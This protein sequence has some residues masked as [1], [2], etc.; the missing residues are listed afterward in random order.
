ML[1]PKTGHANV[2]SVPLLWSDW[3]ATHARRHASAI[4]PSSECPRPD[5]I[6]QVYL[7]APHSSA[8]EWT[9]PCL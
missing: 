3:P 9:I 1:K 8:D 4:T 7:H 5:R 2:R 6:S